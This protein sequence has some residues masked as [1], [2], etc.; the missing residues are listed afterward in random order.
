MAPRAPG[1]PG[2]DGRAKPLSLA[3]PDP[4]HSPLLPP[5]RSNQGTIRDAFTGASAATTTAR[6]DAAVAALGVPC[7]VVFCTA[8]ARDASNARKPGGGMWDFYASPPARPP[9]APPVD[10]AASFYVGDAAGRPAGANTARPDEADF[11]DSDAAFAAGVGLAFHTPEEMW[12]PA[13]PG[14]PTGG[15]YAGKDAGTAARAAGAAAR[16]AMD[17]VKAAAEAARKEAAR[18]AAITNAG[19]ASLFFR[20]ANQAA[21][22]RHRRTA[23]SAAGVAIGGLATPAFTMDLAELAALPGIGKGCLARIS[24]WQRTGDIAEARAADSGGGGGGGG[25]SKYGYGDGR[26]SYGG[27]GE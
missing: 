11:A 6:V 2:G 27:W 22:D 21:G 14:D 18:R 15:A 23:F 10:P 13:D 5:S 3:T 17:A 26:P 12:G 4:T 7:T 19:L 16:A 1:R 25:Y 9:A 20:L 24:E 8:A